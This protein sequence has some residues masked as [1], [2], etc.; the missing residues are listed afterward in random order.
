MS[1]V[2][3]GPRKIL[4]AIQ[5]I[6]LGKFDSHKFVSLCVKHCIL[7]F[8]VIFYC[9]FVRFGKMTH[10]LNL[11]M[12]QSSSPG[13]PGGC[14]APVYSSVEK[15]KYHSHWKKKSFL[16]KTVNFTL[17][18]QKIRIVIN[19]HSFNQTSTAQQLLFR[20]PVQYPHTYKTKRYQSRKEKI[21][22]FYNYFS[23]FLF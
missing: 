5:T 22:L 21:V 14:G 13:C 3:E 1:A 15:R 11:K 10:L 8:G 19:I 6:Y 9:I 18:W 4:L 20:A 23:I 12:C 2:R 16:V 7:F 17:F